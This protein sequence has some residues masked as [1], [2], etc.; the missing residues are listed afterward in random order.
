MTKNKN[1]LNASQSE[2][3]EL[4]NSPNDGALFA[5]SHL[6]D[7]EGGQAVVLQNRKTKK[8]DDNTNH[9][10]KASFKK[11]TFIRQ[12]RTIGI[13][14]FL[15]IFTGCGLGVWYFN[16]ELR[17]DV[18][19]SID[20]TPFLYN[21]DQVMSSTLGITSENEYSNFAT[22][23]QS[24][25]KKP[26]DFTPAENFALA[27]Y[28]ASLA[29]T[30][31]AIGEG[32]INTVITQSLYSEKKFNGEKS[33]FVNISISSMVKV[34]K[35]F[36]L[37]KDSNTVN[38]F[39]GSNPQATTATWNAGGT[40]STDEFKKEM[41]LLPNAIQPYIIS[42]KT[43]TSGNEKS[44]V[45][46]D[47]INGTYSFTI[48]LDTVKSVLYY[49]N[50]VKSTGGLQSYPKFHSIVQTITIDKDW[51]L[52]SIEINDSYDAIVGIKASCKGYLKNH[53]TFNQ[54]V[55]MPV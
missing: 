19:Y 14:I 8:N 29:S 52:V 11:G 17:I 2:D 18:D 6:D 35:C 30:W 45:V 20:P 36:E 37:Y 4:N 50:Q 55:E 53:Y 32:Q 48:E 44:N 9:D 27:E 33:T 16:T 51:N 39:N 7:D 54:P 28:H 10:K 47:D 23:A 25:G 12:L 3:I 41:G 49:V 31:T 21:I 46:Y 40:K 5:T 13:L 43:I 24:Q 42:D 1:D 38:V 22:T 15:G 34:A 26:T